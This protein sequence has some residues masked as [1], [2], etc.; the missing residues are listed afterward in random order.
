V[1]AVSI[2]FSAV[3]Y[4]VL[5]RESDRTSRQQEQAL[6]F[7]IR[8]RFGG[9]VV[10]TEPL[11]AE[12][13]AARRDARGAIIDTLILLN[14]AVLIIS[15]IGA[16]FLAL[17][18]LEPIAKSFDAQSQFAADA[19][20]ALRTPLAV[21]RTELELAKREGKSEELQ[22]R[23][24]YEIDGMTR[25]IEGLLVL[26]RGSSQSHSWEKT[27]IGEL[28]SSQASAVATIYPK[29]SFETKGEQVEEVWALPWALREVVKI[30]LENA[31]KHS[32]K[33]G[34][35][36]LV[37]EQSRSSIIITISDQ[38]PGV[39]EE[40]RAHIF[41]RFYRGS[42]AQEGHGLGLAVARQLMVL[43]KGS[44][45]LDESYTEGAR[46]SIKIPYLKNP[47]LEARIQKD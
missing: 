11:L 31:A 30:V 3:L 16:Y 19:S 21:M 9:E 6:L 40:E 47:P 5:V 12:F 7:R 45:A 8:E 32:P 42:H 26:A 29:L 44:I 39:S 4:P 14:G 33:E 46:F 15:G 41:E 28:L 2:S 10:L 24:L 37:A 27:D 17:R 18:T 22:N 43:Q 38:G 35:I 1:L 20:H 23:L 13:G 36:T 34:A 25:L